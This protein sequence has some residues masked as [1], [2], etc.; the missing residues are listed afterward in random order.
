MFA[1]RHY[2]TEEGQ[3]PFLDWLKKLRD[4]IA[5]VQVI[6]RVNRL[7]AGNFGD[8]K[9]CREG[10]WELRIDQGAGYRVYYSLAGKVIVLLLCAGDKGSQAGDID[11]AIGFW[12][13]WQN[14][15]DE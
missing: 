8:H 7:E 4:P 5:K 3:D 9:P 11:R 10:V 13:N 1:V 15:G 2:L 14:R 6:K 12:K